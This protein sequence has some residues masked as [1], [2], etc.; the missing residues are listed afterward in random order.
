MFKVISLFIPILLCCF[1]SFSLKAQTK[2]ISFENVNVIPM[3]RET[4][5]RD[6]RVVVY[7]GKIV[8][9]EPSS[10]K[11]A[12]SINLRI[13]AEGKYLMPGL[14]ETH[15]HLQNNVENE[16]RLLIANGITCAL[17]MAEYEGQ[18]H[19]AIRE[20]ANNGGILAPVYY[21][22]GPYLQAGHLK[23]PD[24][25]REVIKYHKERGYNFLKIADNL[26]E[27]IYLQLLEEAYLNNI[28]V[29]G[30][31]QRELPLEYSLRMKSIVHMEEFLNIFSKE[32]RDSV[33]FLEET[34]RKIKASG[35][36]VSPTLGIFEMI[37]RYADKS[38][39]EVLKA[40]EELKYLPES[41]VSH[42]KSDKINYT[43]KPWFTAPTSLKR[44]ESELQWQMKLT[45]ILHDNGVPLLAGSDTYGFFLPGFSLHHEL[46]LINSTGISAYETLKMATVIPARYLNRYSV[47]GTVTKGKTADLILLNKNPLEDISNTQSIAG[48]MLKGE[49]FDR[50]ELD[51]ML[52][53]VTASY[54]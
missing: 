5:L 40:G 24:N 18:D 26:P 28:E 11:A 20:K 34:A 19:I 39:F 38:K 23:T 10:V 27:D 13:N 17:N 2:V 30:H 16:F 1:F 12:D 9:I 52:Q 6:Q 42:W 33:L 31:G 45:R 14:T 46:K 3:D 35:V 15:Y 22:T 50:N 44:L 25:V 48:V 37:S 47:S 54:Q 43:T 53:E 36:Y 7:N 8:T 4:V 41:Y 21:T 32:Q 29:I 49:W 51:K